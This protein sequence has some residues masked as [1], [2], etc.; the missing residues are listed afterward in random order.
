MFKLKSFFFSCC[1]VQPIN[2]DTEENFTPNGV[3]PKG[4]NSGQ[5][6]KSNSNKYVVNEKITESEISKGPKLKIVAVEGTLIPLNTEFKVNPGG[7]VG[8]GRLKQDGETYIG[9]L[10]SAK[11]DKT[12]LND[13]VLEDSSVGAQHCLIKYNREKKKYYLQDLGEGSGTFIKIEKELELKSGYII[14]FSDSHMLIHTRDPDLQLPS[15]EEQKH[16]QEDKKGNITIKFLDGPK[17]DQVFRF[18]AEDKVIK[19]GRM[20]DCQIKFDDNNLSRYQCTFKYFNNSW[21]IIDG[22]RTKPSTNGT[23]LLVDNTIEV[24]HEMIVK[25]GQTLFRIEVEPGS[26]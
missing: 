14:S 9:Y 15:D 10:K 17:V 11:G 1:T 21:H 18:K 26:L 8:G 20:N 7:I 22:F 3:V 23:W 5:I 6:V 19:I 4:D 13:I 24:S 25:I 16:L 12:V 2:K